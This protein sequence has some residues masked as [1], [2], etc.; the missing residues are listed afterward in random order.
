MA[1][2]SYQRETP[3]SRQVRKM[4][5]P[6]RSLEKVV[7][8]LRAVVV[9]A[10]GATGRQLVRKL[11]A[12]S[13]WASVTAVTRRPPSDGEL[14]D[15]GPQPEKLHVHVIRNI[16]EPGEEAGIIEAWSGAHVL[17][18]T[19]GTTR[20]QAGSAA[21]FKHVEI[22]LTARAA[23]LARRAEIPCA[24]VLSAQGA[25]AEAYVPSEMLHALLYIQTIGRKEQAMRNAS[26]AQLSIF[27]PGMLNRLKG[28][29][30]LENVVNYLGIGLRVD[31]LAAAMELDAAAMVA[32][33]ERDKKANLAAPVLY[34]GN[35]LISQCSNVENWRVKGGAL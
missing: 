6:P 22:D 29:R 1:T 16:E 24:S 4:S 32:I 31:Q 12:E 26:F 19:L 11:C 8:P 18:N 13:R 17:F 34:E 25:N 20:G 9:G 35:A 2:V 30:L 7:S 33:Y 28:E 3:P 10:T 27:R 5:T 21:A 15:D 14:W 23:E